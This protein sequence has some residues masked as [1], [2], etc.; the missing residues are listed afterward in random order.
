MSKRILIVDD[1]RDL[2]AVLARRCAGLGLEVATANDVPQALASINA[3]PPD[4]MCL[5]VRLPSGNGISVCEMLAAHDTLSK[6]PVIIITGSSDAQIVRHC[7]ALCAYFVPKCAEIWPRI[8]PLLDE[9][10]G[11]FA[12]SPTPV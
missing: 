4:V 3:V 7:H 5:D 2:V 12:A 1:D 6:I 9:L 8:E 10:L 11:P